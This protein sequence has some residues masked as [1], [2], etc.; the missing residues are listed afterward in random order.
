MFFI[1]YIDYYIYLIFF[2]IKVYIY[3]IRFTIEIKFNLN[4]NNF[5]K[6]IQLSIFIFFFIN[7][8]NGIGL[9]YKLKKKKNY[10]L[11][12]FSCML[13]YLSTTNR[14]GFSKYSKDSF[15]PRYTIMKFCRFALVGININDLD[16]TL[17]TNTT[18]VPYSTTTIRNMDDDD[19]GSW[20]PMKR[21]KIRKATSSKLLK[22]NKSIE[23]R[24]Q[25]HDTNF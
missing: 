1:H 23:L 6:R 24:P 15:P 11:L 10:K 13:D 21:L 2:L 9:I 4:N 16:C 14:K 5:K 7:W 8:L 3:R 19:D 22:K 25:K 12:C 18:S 17:A 20:A